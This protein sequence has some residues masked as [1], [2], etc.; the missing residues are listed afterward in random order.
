MPPPAPT[1]GR[2]RRA[3]TAAS[4]SSAA[5]RA[6]LIRSVSDATASAPIG[7]DPNVRRLVAETARHAID[8]HRLAEPPDRAQTGDPLRR[9]G[10]A[11]EVVDDRGRARVRSVRPE[12]AGDGRPDF[13]IR[14]DD[15]LVGQR[16]LCERRCRVGGQGT[17][18]PDRRRAH[19]RIGV[20]QARL[21]GGHRRRR[22][23]QPAEGPERCRPDR[24][25]GVVVDGPDEHRPGSLD[26]RAGREMAAI[27]R[28]PGSSDRSA[29]IRVS[30]AVG[31][32]SGRPDPGRPP[33]PAR[34]GPRAG[35]R[36]RSP[37]SAGGCRPR[38]RAQQRRQGAQ[39]EDL[40]ARE[41]RA[42]GQEQQAGQ[43]RADLAGDAVVEGQDLGPTLPRDDVVEGAPGG[44][45]DA[46]LGHLLGEPEYRGRGIQNATSHRPKPPRYTSGRSR[47]AP[48]TP[49]RA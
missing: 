25:I 48:A 14:I 17:N 29:P 15:Q 4:S 35:C 28:T 6:G 30:V 24:G 32:A 34:R 12:Q 26:R 39:P 8:R 43:D 40:V 46:A 41:E 1:G 45:R 3:T 42:G 13:R 16:Q 22:A 31:S 36:G 7:R 47:A 10:T 33:A 23:A 9:A 37:R 18:R 21:G 27:R 11:H 44:V 38:P 20:D 49:K 19:A 5:S 2:G